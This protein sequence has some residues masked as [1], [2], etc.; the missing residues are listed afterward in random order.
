MVL[1]LQ[2]AVDLDIYLSSTLVLMVSSCSTEFVPTVY[3]LD[4]IKSY[5]FE[6]LVTIFI[7]GETELY[8]LT[9]YNRI[10]W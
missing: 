5:N 8:L 2:N 4:G 3:F 1:S 6:A 9:D 10:F 7:I